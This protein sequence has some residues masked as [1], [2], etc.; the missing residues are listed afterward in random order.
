[1]QS[2]NAFVRLSGLA[3]EFDLTKEKWPVSICEHLG[4]VLYGLLSEFEQTVC[5]DLGK[6]CCLNI[7]PVV[8]DG[9]LPVGPDGI[10]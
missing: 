7:W 2:S 9:F 8:A 1:M 5:F 6:G 10:R 3:V 4:M